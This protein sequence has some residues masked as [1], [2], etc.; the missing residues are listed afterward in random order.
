M[1]RKGA[2]NGEK[3]TFQIVFAW[4]VK[5]IFRPNMGDEVDWAGIAATCGTTSSQPA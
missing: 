4:G 1:G 3:G 5:G 2:E